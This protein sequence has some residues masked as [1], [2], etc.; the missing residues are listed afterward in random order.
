[1]PPLRPLPDVMPFPYT[2]NP[3]HPKPE[4]GGVPQPLIESFST[5]ARL[6]ST[7]LRECLDLRRRI[8][9]R[10]PLYRH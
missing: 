6:F 8:P 9:R 1:M 2:G 10:T 3:L 5:L 7:R 4:T